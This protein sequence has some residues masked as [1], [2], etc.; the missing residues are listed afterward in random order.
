M[1]RLKLLAVVPLI[2]LITLTSLNADNPEVVFLH[3]ND[4]HAR[5]SAFVNSAGDSIGGYPVL[6]GYLDSV[7]SNSTAP[8]F[9]LHAGDDFQGTP[10]ST[11]TKGASQIR[12]LNAIRPDA[13]VL[14]NHEFDYGR[15]SLDSL[16]NQTRFPVLAANLWDTT[17]DTFFTIPAAQ[18]EKGGITVSVIGLTAPDLFQLTLPTNVQGLEMLDAKQVVNE[19]AA[20]LEARTDLTVVLS[21]M[22]F[23][24]D[25]LLAASLGSSSP[26]DLIIGGHSHTI[27]RH[28]H[29]VN[30]IYIT[31]AGE[32]GE[33]LGYIRARVD[34]VQN[35]FSHFQYTLLPVSTSGVTPRS[36]I[37]A[38]VDSLKSTATQTLNTVIGTLQ[39]DWN[40]NRHGESNLGNWLTDVMREYADADIA[41][42]NSGGIRKDLPAGP[43][44]IR[45][46]WEISPFGNH[47]VRFHITGQQLLK[48][49]RHQITDPREFLQV[50]GLQYRYRT[51]TRELLSAQV[52]GTQLRPDSIYIIVTNNYV[53]SHFEEFFGLP[54]SSVQRVSHLPAIDREVFTKAVRDQG[55]ISSRIEGRIRAVD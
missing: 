37:A 2:A 53:H 20:R 47:F 33:Y 4:F 45:D 55:T 52:G 15:Q 31:Q 1:H 19:Q 26:V 46:L 12:I 11:L 13:F 41:F 44:R 49:I 50:S 9:T 3:W 36:E 39:T 28:S 38:I 29:N 10:I 17:T 8:V 48:I 22:G 7:E 27:L 18:L 42:Q 51:G 16:M 24:E 35:S 14:G 5:N 43:I 23:R 21:H 34:T 32:H 40:R 54:V 30:G 25:S 6:A